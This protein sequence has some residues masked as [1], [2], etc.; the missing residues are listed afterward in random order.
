MLDEAAKRGLDITL[1]LLLLVV[2]PLF[3][4]RSHQ[5]EPGAVFIAPIA[6]AATA[7]VACSSSARWRRRAAP[8]SQ[9]AGTS[10]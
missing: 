3:S 6:S 2:L 10:G 5:L 9:S 8:R 4:S 1:S 7:A